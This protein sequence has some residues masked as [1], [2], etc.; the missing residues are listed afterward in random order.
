MFC[1]NCGFK[2][3]ETDAKFCASCGAVEEVPSE[4][5]HAGETMVSSQE[6]SASVMHE[7]SAPPVHDYYAPPPMHQQAPP[8]PD[9]QN[10]NHSIK[11]TFVMQKT[12]L[13]ISIGLFGAGMYFVGLISI[14]PLVIMAGDVLLFEEN[15]WLKW[16]AVKAVSVVVLFTILSSFLSL[17]NN[18]TSFLND[19]VFLFRGYVDLSALN[20]IISILRTILSFI[21]TL[22]LLILGFKALKLGNMKV[23]AVDKTINKH[24]Y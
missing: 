1:R 13:G 11:E 5:T 16:T 18:S 24:M 14:F 9:Q 4:A 6:Q 20:R 3:K 7:P 2:H 23:A 12:K 21:Q 22:I 10:K 19:I 17:L 15:D 8:S